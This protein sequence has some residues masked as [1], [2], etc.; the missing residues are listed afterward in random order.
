[1]ATSKDDEAGKFKGMPHRHV[2]KEVVKSSSTNLGHRASYS[3]KALSSIEMVNNGCVGIRLRNPSALMNSSLV[4]ALYQ[5]NESA[6]RPP[7]QFIGLISMVVVGDV[8]RGHGEDLVEIVKM[9][10]VHRRQGPTK[11]SHSK[12]STVS[13]RGWRE[14]TDSG[15]VEGVRTVE[16]ACLRTV[17]CSTR[18]REELVPYEVSGAHERLVLVCVDAIHGC[19]RRGEGKEKCQWWE[20]GRWSRKRREMR[21]LW[22]FKGGPK[23]M[24]NGVVARAFF[25][26]NWG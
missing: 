26:R 6:L 23:R 19:D 14:A 20:R 2:S 10:G 4:H 22:V 8:D 25:G 12:S 7:N 13:M 18:Q 21:G 9:D 1:M 24:V 11:R 16:P 15:I 5:L 17:A 3:Q